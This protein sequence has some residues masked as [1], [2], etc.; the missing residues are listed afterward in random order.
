MLRQTQ[1]ECEHRVEQLQR[2]LENSMQTTSVRHDSNVTQ[3]LTRF[4]IFFTLFVHTFASVPPLV[5]L[6]SSLSVKWFES[7]GVFLFGPSAQI[8]NGH[9]SPVV[10]SE[11]VRFLKKPCMRYHTSWIPTLKSEPAAGFGF[12]IWFNV[13][14][15]FSQSQLFPLTKNCQAEKS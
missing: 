13:P 4:T 6:I 14:L 12:S 10:L 15:P 7:A 11:I 2:Q 1:A 8:S 5:N 3:L 9:S